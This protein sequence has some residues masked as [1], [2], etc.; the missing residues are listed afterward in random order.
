V[1]NPQFREE[2]RK[3]WV[4]A[5][6]RCSRGI[7]YTKLV[8]W[9]DASPF[10]YADGSNDVLLRESDAARVKA[11]HAQG[12]PSVEHLERLWAE[13]L[14]SAPSAPSGGRFTL[15]ANVKCPHCGHELPYNKGV[16]DIG[17][18]LHDTNII[19]LD[20]AIVVGDTDRSSWQVRVDVSETADG[21]QKRL[22]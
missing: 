16:R 20:E 9:F 6:P 3:G 13:C 12:T 19:L 15:W 14:L 18:R 21:E 8:Q 4:L 5:C 22:L 17:V 10:F 2:R 7:R 11:A 1:R